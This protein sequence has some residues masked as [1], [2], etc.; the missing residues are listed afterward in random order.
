MRIGHRLLQG[1][2]IVGALL[3]TAAPGSAAPTRR[4]QVDQRGDFALIG[5]TVVHDCAT[6]PAGRVTVGTVGMCGGNTADSSAD[7][8]WQADNP[9]GGA[10]AST[11]ITPAAARSTA[12][13]AIPAGA[14]VT[15]ARLYWTAIRNVADDTQVVLDRA[16]AGAFTASV[17]ADVPV[18]NVVATTGNMR[19]YYQASADVT[20]VVRTNGNGAYRV[21]GIDTIALANLNE[22]SAVVA[23][24]MVVIYQLDSQPNRNLTIFDGLDIVENVAARRTLDIPLSGFQVP[25]AGFNAKLGVVAYEGD[26]T[27]LGDSLFFNPATFPTA[28]SDAINPADNFFNSSR[29]EMGAAVF[30]IGDLPQLT[31]LAGSMS[32]VDIDVVNVT[33]RVQQGDTSATIRVQTTGDLIIT[34]VFVTSISTLKPDFT[35]TAKTFTNVTRSDGTVRPGDILEYT[36]T[37]TNTGNDSGVNVVMTD[38]LPASLNFVAGSLAVTAGPNAGTKTDAVIADDQG[39]YNAAT[40]TVTVRLGTNANGTMGGVLAEGASTTVVFRAQVAANATGTVS[41]QAVVTAAGLSGAPSA[42]YPSDG[43]GVQAGVPPT[44]TIVDFCNMDSDCPQARPVCRKVDHPFTCVECLSNADCKM[45]NAPI[46]DG[47]TFTCRACANDGDCSGATPACHSTGRCTQCS[48]TNMTQCTGNMPRC[49]VPVGTCSGCT[50]NADCMGNTPICDMTSKLCRACAMDSECPA[51]APAC[52][53]AGSCGECSATNKTLCVAPKPACDTAANK[54]AECAVNAD[55]PAARP[56]C[57]PTSKTCVVCASNTDCKDPTPTCGSNGVCVG[58]SSDAD[59]GGLTPICATQTRTCVPCPSDGACMAKDTRFP[60]CQTTGGLAGACTECSATNASRCSGARP[61]CI[62]SLGFCGCTDRDGDSECGG[63][64]SGVVCNA[65]VGICVPG[66]STAAG[67][68]GCPANQTCNA[69]GNVIGSCVIGACTTDAECSAPRPKCDTGVNPRVC[70]QC[71]VNGDC[72]APMVCDSAGTKTCVECTPT[73]TA[74]CTANGAGIRCLG[75]QTCGCMA[76]S[77]CGGMSSGRVCDTG[78][79][80]CSPGCRGTGGNG[81]PAGLVC[82]SKDSQIGRCLTPGEADAGMD[83]GSDAAAD[84]PVADTGGGTSDARDAG[85]DL[86]VDLAA[87]DRPVDRPGAELGGYTDLDAFN[88]EPTSV[89]Q[90]A[91]PAGGGCKCDV[92]AQRPG[93]GAGLWLMVPAIAVVAFRRRRRR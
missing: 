50:T 14:T 91:Y 93:R 82:T 65:P 15:H 57:H 38:V 70:V 23:W 13:L 44:T 24:S 60:A 69:V 16:G 74:N 26:L 67:R 39:E 40:R 53:A 45:P 76:D 33:D 88:G 81:C 31:G 9:A 75:N 27:L 21:S 84:G 41:N 1:G 19:T 49:N 56:V 54:C 35:T 8:F 89:N 85:A 7:V 61:Q 2:L 48:A 78:I 77:E 25:A 63:P 28:L 72:P 58:C 47:P 43:N 10:T 71:L 66:C 6:P 87:P 4:F 83:A 5:N 11:A 86:A 80:K 34:G 22:S 37:T 12:V 64:M 17:T 32:G 79:S 59:C 62:A 52:L 36:I 51:A 90:G 18:S 73:Q 42:M 3:A 20:A 30:A 68:N 29:S 46:C 92:G 55:C